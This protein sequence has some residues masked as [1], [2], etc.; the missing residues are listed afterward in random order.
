MKLVIHKDTWK[1]TVYKGETFN[2]HY[3]PVDIA[4]DSISILFFLLRKLK[5]VSIE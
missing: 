2:K 4:P 1:L 3:W 5:Y